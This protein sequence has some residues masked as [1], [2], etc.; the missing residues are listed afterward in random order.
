MV[1]RNEWQNYRCGRHG[2]SRHVHDH[3]GE[4]GRVHGYVG[5]SRDRHG[6]DKHDLLFPYKLLPSTI[7]IRRRFLSVDCISRH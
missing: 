4:R 2:D 6:D 7:W 5:V 1:C 3:D